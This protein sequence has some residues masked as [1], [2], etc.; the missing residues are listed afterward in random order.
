VILSGYGNRIKVDNSL[1]ERLRLLEEKVATL[2]SG[3]TERLTSAVSQM[4][5][6]LRETLFGKNGTL[7]YLC[8]LY[9]TH[10]C[11]VLSAENRKHYT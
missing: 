9:I 6:E 1:D 7:S 2:K 10:V 5:P 8:L 11:P 3:Q 4:L